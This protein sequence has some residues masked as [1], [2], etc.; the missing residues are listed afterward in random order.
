M[1]C[2]FY[3]AYFYTRNT[4]VRQ[5]SILQWQRMIT[6]QCFG[7]C[8]SKKSSCDGLIITMSRSAYSVSFK[9]HH[10][11]EFQTLILK[12]HLSLWSDQWSVLDI[13]YKITRRCLLN[14]LIY[15]NLTKKEKLTKSNIIFRL[16]LICL[17]RAL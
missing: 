7:L 11:G 15:S 13:D 14:P 12:L 8:I 16:S 4:V 2:L 9:N 1:Q 3:C 5:F 17:F 6:I 10:S